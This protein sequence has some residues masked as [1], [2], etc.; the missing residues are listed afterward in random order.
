VTDI[1][2]KKTSLGREIYIKGHAGDGVQKEGSVVCAAISTL[3]QTLAQN[4]FDYE[5]EG[6]VDI[7]GVSLKSGDA[8]FNYVTDNEDVNKVVDGIC[9]GFYLVSDSFPERVAFD[10]I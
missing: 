8:Y 1:T 2:V 6:E 10:I 5:D 3:A 4:L 7:I 9:K